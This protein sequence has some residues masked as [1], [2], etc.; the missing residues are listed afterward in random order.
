M[1]S[2]LV[3]N[4][5]T[6]PPDI[7]RRVDTPITVITQRNLNLEQDMRFLFNGQTRNR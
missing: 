5:S 6:Q 7:M 3:E 2:I 1:S 4:K